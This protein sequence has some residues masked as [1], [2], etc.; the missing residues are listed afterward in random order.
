MS[1]QVVLDFDAS[2]WSDIAA[3]INETLA[4]M[5]E[6]AGVAPRIVAISHAGGPIHEFTALVVVE[7][8]AQ[9]ER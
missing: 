1:T 3:Q 2:R 4:R 7:T 9:V 8:S 6:E 5:E